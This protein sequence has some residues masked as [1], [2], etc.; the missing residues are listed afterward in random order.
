[1]TGQTELGGDGGDLICILVP[2]R[3]KHAEWLGFSACLAVVQC[4]LG[5][6][7]KTL[8]DP[9]IRVLLCPSQLSSEPV[10]CS[11]GSAAGG[12]I[13]GVLPV[14]LLSSQGLNPILL[15]QAGALGA[16]VQK[17]KPSITLISAPSLTFGGVST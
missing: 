16:D 15:P 13:P 9:F 5:E 1:M 6:R 12:M 4:Q 17:F 14:G 2:E 3:L 8:L 10:M 7:S 11:Q